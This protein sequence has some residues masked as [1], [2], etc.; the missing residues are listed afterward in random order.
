MQRVTR[1]VAYGL[2]R[3][4]SD[5][6][7]S[8]LVVAGVAAA[9][10]LLA[11]V[12]VGSLVAQDRALARAVDELPPSART[13]RAAWFGVPGE[14]DEF[15]FYLVIAVMVAILVGMLTYFR[16]RDWL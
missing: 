5:G 16:R 2:H 6:A 9:G 8:A 11:S 1:A 4:R 7:R 14:G 13:I 15:D 10:L 12:L 3:L